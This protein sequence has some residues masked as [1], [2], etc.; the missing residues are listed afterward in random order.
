M[1]TATRVTFETQANLSGDPRLAAQ[2]FGR[3]SAEPPPSFDPRRDLDAACAF[4]DAEGYVVLTDCLT[5]SELTELNAFCEL[6]QAERPE[7]WGLSGRRKPH[8]RNQ[9][10]IYSQPLLDHPELDR[11]TRPAASFGVVGKLM[12]GDERPRFSEFNFRESPAGAGPGAMNF[13]HDAVREDRFTREPYGPP[14]WI[15]AIH[16]LTDVEPGAPVFCVVPRSGRFASLREAF[17]GLGGGYREVPLYGAAGACVLYD[18]ATFHTRLDG[19]GERMRR[20]WHQYYARGGWLRTDTRYIRAPSPALADW[21]LAPE[22]LALSPDPATRLFFSHWN[23]TMGEW[24]ASGF[25]PDVRRAMPRGE[26]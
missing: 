16:Y 24:A 17:E 4:F 7:A 9:G 23:T 8:H 25:D 6:T 22:R 10:L 1:T 12:G 18:T 20:T 26:Q 14:D 11:Y 21:N 19:D 3:V 5:A 15:C 2:G 13:H